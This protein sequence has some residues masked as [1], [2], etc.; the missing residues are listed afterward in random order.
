MVSDGGGV[1]LSRL[2][3]SCTCSSSDTNVIFEVGRDFDLSPHPMFVAFHD[4][5]APSIINIY[6]QVRPRSAQGRIRDRISTCAAAA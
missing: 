5:F 3:C 2:L 6:S 1:F 4:Y